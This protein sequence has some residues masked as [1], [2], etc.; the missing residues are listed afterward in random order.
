M[1]KVVLATL[2]VIVC[3]AAYNKTEEE[4]KD[5]KKWM[6]KE[7]GDMKNKYKE[8]KSKMDMDM[9]KTMKT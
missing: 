8:M 3:A 1:K 4:M 5:M 7:M 6:E 9:Y 2:A